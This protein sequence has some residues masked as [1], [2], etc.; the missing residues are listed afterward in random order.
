MNTETLVEI[1]NL[2]QDELDITISGSRHNIDPSA[3]Y[4][5]NASQISGKIIDIVLEEEHTLEDY[6]FVSIN[7]DLP[8]YGEEVQVVVEGIDDTRRIAQGIRRFT[9]RKGDHWSVSYR[10]T[11]STKL[12]GKEDCQRV[13]HWRPLPNVIKVKK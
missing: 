2:I 10:M 8:V 3:V 1:R 7:E 11:A 4:I 13:T 12:S 5:N 9:D 6:N